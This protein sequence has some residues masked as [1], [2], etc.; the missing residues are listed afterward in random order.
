MVYKLILFL[1][2]LLIPQKGSKF[3]RKI[4]PQA[5]SLRTLAALDSI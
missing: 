3:K 4:V 2:T 1:K 5:V